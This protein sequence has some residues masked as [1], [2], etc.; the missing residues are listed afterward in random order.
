MHVLY[1]TAHGV[2]VGLAEHAAMVTE[3]L[4]RDSLRKIP[5]QIRDDPGEPDAARAMI[6]RLDVFEQIAGHCLFGSNHRPASEPLSVTERLAAALAVW[7]IQAHR[8]LAAHPNPPNLA[9]VA[10]VQALI[11]TTSG[12]ITEAAAQ[13]GLIDSAA[14]E[15]FATLIDT[16]Q[17]G[18]TRAADRWAELINPAARTDPKLLGAASEVRAAIAAAAHD[19]TGWAAPDMI[20]SRIHLPIAV[21]QLQI[22]TAPAVDLAHLTRDIAVT[23]PTLTAPARAIAMRAQSAVER[24]LD[25][26][27]SRY[28]GVDWVNAGDVRTNRI[29]PLPDPVRRG[30]ADS[31]DHVIATAGQAAA[32]AATLTPPEGPNGASVMLWRRDHVKQQRQHRRSHHQNARIQIDEQPPP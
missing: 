9:C 30:L 3:Q 25:Q 29:I 16:S 21:G 2:T 14:S 11:A 12:V 8:S 22:A 7:D 6:S 24:A 4:R 26:G 15:R 31:A 28:L 13:T 10:R 32:A 1:V 23:E 5:S 18:W 20:A 17:L 27:E 19:Q